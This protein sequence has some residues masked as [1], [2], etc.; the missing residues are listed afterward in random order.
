MADRKIIQVDTDAFYASARKSAMICVC[1][2]GPLPSG[3]SMRVTSLTL[4]EIEKGFDLMHSGESIQ[5][6]VAY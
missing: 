3:A 5:S 1:A 2:V 4:D 6:V